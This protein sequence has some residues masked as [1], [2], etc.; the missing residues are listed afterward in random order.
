MSYERIKELRRDL[1]YHKYRYYHLDDPVIPDAEYDR[2]ERELEDLEEKH[3][4]HSDPHSP[5]KMVG[6]TQWVVE[7]FEKEE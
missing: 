5:T 4:E 7:M 2:L 3:P 1:L 6:V